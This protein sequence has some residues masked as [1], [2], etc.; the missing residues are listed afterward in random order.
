MLRALKLYTSK[1]ILVLCWFEGYNVNNSHQYDK[2][3]YF[4]N[5]PL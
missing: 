2:Y 4:Y 5:F 1:N 3:H